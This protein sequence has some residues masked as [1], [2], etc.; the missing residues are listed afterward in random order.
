MKFTGK[1]TDAA[2]GRPLP[3][4]NVYWSNQDG[5]PDYKNWGTTTN[6]AGKYDLGTDIGSLNITASFLGYERQTQKI[7]VTP[8]QNAIINFQLKPTSTEL[9]GVEVIASRLP[10]P[11]QWKQKLI[12]GLAI[13]ITIFAIYKFMKPKF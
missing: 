3:F 7:P 9:K 8:V 11:A 5:T 6:Q 10:R 2:T 1:V 13:T 4:A 12:I